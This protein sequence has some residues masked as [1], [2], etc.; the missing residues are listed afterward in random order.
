MKGMVR[1]RLLELELKEL[2]QELQE[3]LM[4]Q[5]FDPNF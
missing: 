2:D 3:H 4:F 5:V 1:L